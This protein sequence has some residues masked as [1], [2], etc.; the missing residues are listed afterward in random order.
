MI[1]TNPIP[2]WSLL[3]AAL[4][5]L[6]PLAVALIASA[7]L[8]ESEARQAA[9][10]PLAAFALAV[11]G[12]VTAGFA[13]HYGGIGLIVDHPDLAELVWEWSAIPAAWGATWGMAGLAGFGF[14]VQNSLTYLLLLS[15]LP[16]VTTAVLLPMLALRGRVPAL[17][18][19]LFGLLVAV[20]GYP[21]LANWIQG[22]GWLAKL[23]FNIG[24]GHGYIDFGG[25]SLFLLGGGVALAAILAFLP[26]LP[27]R[28]GPAEL[29]PVHL[30]LLAITGAGLLLAGST[31]WLLAWPLTDWGQVPAVRVVAT[32]LLAAAGGAALPLFYTW[33]VASRADALQGA[34]G[35]AA[36][37]VA[38]LATAPFLTPTSALLLGAV[39][40]LMM[41]LGAYLVEH[42]L[43]LQ[44]RGGVL[45]TFGLPALVGLLAAGILADGTAGA[46]YNGVGAGEYLGV[47]GQGVTGLLAAAG[48][49]PD[50]PGQFI[51]QAIGVAVIFLLGF[52]A[53]S[54]LAVPM[55]IV[56]RAWGRRAE[57]AA[58]AEAIELA[59]QVESSAASQGLTEEIAVSGT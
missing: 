53:A 38:G 16:W 44:D 10:T 9:L 7:G 31:G 39:A 41:I 29:P 24:A 23:G 33:F 6:I 21:L 57:P 50:W 55:A 14:S 25:A 48:L 47:S 4:A 30:P 58:P 56:V 28:Q 5:F 20:V 18:T 52:L 45:T 27:R 13:L 42:W 1:E 40:G 46:G 34:R 17:A 3:A 51:A 8:P 54:I 49:T 15:A 43:R 59:S 2:M 12:Y 37:W 32:A 19:A 35:L 36:G 26:R 11:V 22:G